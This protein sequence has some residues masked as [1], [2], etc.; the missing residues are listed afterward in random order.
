[1]PSADRTVPFASSNGDGDDDDPPPSH[2]G[3]YTVLGRLGAGGM[4]VVLAAH[5][6]A[7]DRN[8]AI[9][10][11]WPAIERAMPR[12]TADLEREA[13]AMAKLAHP[14]VVT[15]FEVDRLGDRIY[16]AMELVEGS[17]LRAWQLERARGW[18]ELVEIYLAA[19]RGL[20]AAHAAGLV[21][22]DFKPDNV[23]IGRDGRP[24]VSDF[25]LVAEA[26]DPRDGARVASAITGGAAPGVDLTS[27][28]SAV[29]T[30]AYMA[31]EQ[32]IGATVDARSDQFAF[33]VA[34]WEGLW[35]RLPFSGATPGELRAAITA[36]TLVEPTGPRRVPR[37]LEAALRRGLA[38]DPGARWPDMAAL[39]DEL[40]RRTRARRR[41]AVI[42]IAAGAAVASAAAAVLVAGGGGAPEPCAPPAAR[43][44][45]VW[46]PVRGAALRARLTAV[47]P[48]AGAIRAA[49][50]V[51]ALDAG[52][53]DWTAMHVAAC[54]A[55]RVDGRQSD[56]L[57]D[58]RM[59][60]L[61]RWLA[62]LGASVAAVEQAADLPAIDHAVHVATELSPLDACADLR[63][64]GEAV[65]PPAEPAR[66]ATAEALAERARALEVAQG[67]GRLDG[68]LDQARALTAAARAL[69]DAP[70]VAAALRAQA[71]IEIAVGNEAFASTTLRALA[72]AAARA[73]DDRA[74]AFAWIHLFKSLGV[75]QGKRD[76]ATALLPTAT[77]AVLRAGEPAELRG[78]LLY[79]QGA[80][81]DYGGKPADG[82][83]ALTQARQVLEAAGGR[84]PTS[85]YAA[86]LADVVFEIGTSHAYAGELDASI[87]S[88][89][90]AIARWR[91]VY[92]PDSPDEAFGWQNLG[93][94]RQIA[95]APDASL[96]AFRTAARIRAA[97]IGDSPMLVASLIGVAAVLTDLRRWDEAL[98]TY[99]RAL[100]IDR[101]QLASDDLA[102]TGVLL[103]RGLTLGHLGRLDEAAAAYDEVIALYARVG[104]NTYNLPSA[105]VNRA[106]LAARRG[107][108]EAAIADHARAIALL[109]Q[110]FDPRSRELLHPLVGRAACL[111]RSG[112]AAEAIGSLE[113]AL[114]L[115]AAPSD[116]LERARAQ[117]Y[118][119]RARVETRRDVA[120]GLALVRA[121]RAGIAAEP[122]YVHELDRWLAGR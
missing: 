29:G 50:I 96:A 86:R 109:E 47:D 82:L 105:L 116:A 42:A 67:A 31:R 30:P 91:D 48:A 90:D 20:A 64:L 107:R 52:A 28:G 60:C 51:G 17:T 74:A 63:A 83:A 34:L 8:V 3:R 112:H 89:D 122:A 43:V 70:T 92:G 36:G 61:D 22:R 40:A 72:Q 21:H 13:Q 56:T 65:P 35:G 118:L 6:P 81:L 4:G 15:V 24:R 108:C 10:L 18:R 76:E 84:S 103:G 121:A 106:E 12:S 59:A 7:L 23:L 94:V 119:G 1:M 19:G 32:W 11:L 95:G 58:L 111:V 102:V 41:G 37:W 45:A 55:T 77:A 97:R 66:R 71:R 16:V 117:Y 38:V 85:P 99:D 57:L 120:G 69:D 54:R 110:L 75:D 101:A 5:D 33:C 2:L 14:N 27:R 114:A 73:R 68:L 104:G 87:A 98:A 100:R 46:S 49:K 25:G 78:E 44:A 62:E 93:A 80:F 79:S 39:L 26:A 88:Y 113:R 53:R 9:K 115:Q